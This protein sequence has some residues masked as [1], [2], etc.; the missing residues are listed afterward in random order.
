[1]KVKRNKWV[2]IVTDSQ[3]PGAGGTIDKAETQ[4]WAGWVAIWPVRS[5]EIRENMRVGA[6]TT[7]N[8]RMPYRAGIA[9]DMRVKYGDRSFDIKGI[10]NPEERNI[11]LDLVCEE[12]F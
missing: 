5:K 9:H 8:I 3:A 2:S 12:I 1:L 6:K 7:H 4:V 11:Y 10:V